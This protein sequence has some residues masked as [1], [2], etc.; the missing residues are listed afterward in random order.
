M[1]AMHANPSES[2]L[3]ALIARF[4]SVFDNRSG[5]CVGADEIAALFHE[6]GVIAMRGADG[7]QTCSPFDFAKPRVDLLR[8]G[9][10]TGFHEWET[11][12]ES[13]ADGDLALRTSRYEKTGTMDGA[14]YAGKG[15]KFFQFIRVQG[16]WRILSLA[17]ADDE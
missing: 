12:H 5:D 15:T 16:R 1:A 3:D 2:E 14:P 4:Y 8:G 9:R 6:S 7:F 11:S 17:W 13:R 10:L